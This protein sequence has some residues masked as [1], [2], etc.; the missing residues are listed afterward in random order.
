M[1]RAASLQAGAVWK[2]RQTGQ[3]PAARQELVAAEAVPGVC[4]DPWRQARDRRRLCAS[5]PSSARDASQIGRAPRAT[6]AS[7]ASQTTPS[8]CAGCRPTWAARP[9]QGPSLDAV[10]RGQLRAGASRAV[11]STLGTTANHWCLTSCKGQTMGQ[12]VLATVV[13]IYAPT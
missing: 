10:R 11:G 13:Q 8:R 12:H 9:G 5:C 3:G 2:L 4:A 7:R 1:P 6:A